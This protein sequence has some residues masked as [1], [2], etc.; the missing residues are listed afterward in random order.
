MHLPH[1]AVALAL[2][3]LAACTVDPLA[4]HAC[5]EMGCADGLQIDFSYKQAGSYVVEV[6]LDGVLTT[7]KATLPLAASPPTPCDRA[8]VYLT[9]S[10]SMLPADQQSIG[11]VI[12]TATTAKHATV[13]IT[14]DGA[15]LASLDRDVT[16]T[17]TPGPNGP[18][19]EPKECRSA[20]LSF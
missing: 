19:C 9:L 11:G 16:W 12:V 14:R 7:C 10:G 1:A 2:L 17:V 18:D 20:K 15:A 13:K 3:S 8:G 6:T 5:T 4:P